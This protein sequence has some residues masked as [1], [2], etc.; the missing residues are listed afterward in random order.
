MRDEK[1]GEFWRC[2]RCLA[3]EVEVGLL[4]DEKKG[5]YYCLR[6]CFVGTKEEVFQAYEELRRNGRRTAQSAEF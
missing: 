1:T 4:F 5:E 2:P 6:C 3:K